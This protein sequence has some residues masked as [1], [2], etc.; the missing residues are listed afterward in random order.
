VGAVG[1]AIALVVVIV[2]VLAVPVASAAIAERQPWPRRVRLAC[3]AH[4]VDLATEG[5]APITVLEARVIDVSD[6]QHTPVLVGLPG[7]C[8]ERLLL[9]PETADADRRRLRYWQAELIPVLIVGAA[10]VD[11]H[12]PSG[13]VRGARLVPVDARFV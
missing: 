4:L 9:D 1:P 5:G 3:A 6:S 8:L 10:T 7:G 2:V 13:M 11:V 12:G